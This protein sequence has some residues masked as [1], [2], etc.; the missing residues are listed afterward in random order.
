MQHPD[1]PSFLHRKY[2]TQGEMPGLN[3]SSEVNSAARLTALRTGKHFSEQDFSGRIDNYLQS[4]HDFGVSGDIGKDR[5]E[6]AKRE[7]RRTMFKT[8]IL[9]K[10]TTAYDDI[11][12]SYWQSYKENFLPSQGRL[13]E[14]THSNKEKKEQMQKNDV[15]PLLTDQR[16]SLEKWLDYFLSSETDNIPDALKYW[17]FRSLVQLKTF[18]KGK[19]SSRIVFHRRSKESLKKFPELHPKSLQVV[20]DAMI[21][22]H[23]GKVI[24]FSEEEFGIDI[25]SEEYELF[26]HYLE[27]EKFADLYAWAY[28]FINPIPEHLLPEVHGEWKPYPK[29]SDP[30][31][32]TQD[33]HGK[34]SGLCITG[35]RDAGQYINTGDIYVF[36]SNNEQQ[37]PIFPRAAIHIV[38]DRI[39]EV[40]GIK[41]KQNLDSYITP[42][43][44]EKLKEF[45]DSELF[46][47]PLDD[48]KLL[49]ALE[50]K[51]DKNEPLNKDDLI[52]LYGIKTP[53]EGFGEKSDPR[54]DTLRQRRNGE[55]DMMMIFDCSS[56]N[57]IAH[58]HT[59]ITEDTKVYDGPLFPGI[60][61]K[62]KHVEHIYTRF[63]DR[64]IRRLPIQ[65]SDMTK[66]QLIIDLSK[67]PFHIDQGTQSFLQQENLVHIPIPQG[68]SVTIV[69]LRLEDL[70]LKKRPIGNTSNFTTDS[71]LESV[72]WRAQAFN[73]RSVST[74]IALQYRLQ[75]TTQ[76][77]GEM[78]TLGMEPIPLDSF[79]DPCIFNMHR[80]KA[81]QLHLGFEPVSSTH[82]RCPDVLA[83]MYYSTDK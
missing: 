65:V 41:Y 62:L 20:F 55:Q 60:F 33:L 63:P 74:A 49:A 13:N 48:M 18:E 78:I 46:Q 44:E 59:E 66:E 19:D 64:E 82:W 72:L 36:F 50:Q 56:L 70:G 32:L 10:Y 8:V 76:P 52:F 29:N 5:K 23:Q 38:D 15:L 45:P 2:K 16:K 39:A 54:I 83:F 17:A 35:D 26:Q 40:R 14:W 30:A 57:Q 7:R 58:S 11:P 3:I 71:S 25:Q 22:K 77:C 75:Y 1:F 31:I 68:T 4:L 61:E 42:V 80:D 24:D 79:E 47:K 81:R 53:I 34:S 43:V 6:L 12:L 73:L 67:R 51:I 28:E 37:Q 27:T 9:D 21:K 69:M